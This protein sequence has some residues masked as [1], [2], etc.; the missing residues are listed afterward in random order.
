MKIQCL[1]AAGTVTGSR[2][3]LTTEKARVLI[4]CGLFQGYKT[5]REK[6]RAPLPFNAAELDAIVLT[7]A[8][9]DHS[10][11]LPVLCQK[12]FIGPVYCHPATQALCGILLP[13]SGHIQEEDARYANEH[14]TSKHQPALPL[15]DRKQAVAALKSLTPHDYFDPIEIGDLRLHL[16]PVGHILGAS[17]VVIEHKGK[18]VI[19]SGDVGRPDDILMNPPEPLPE[20]DA[21]FLES[22]YG[23]R[24]HESTSPWDTLADIVNQTA[25]LGGV[26]SIPCFAVG[27]AQTLQHMLDSLMAQRRIPDMPV[28]LDSPMAIDASHIYCR[29]RSFHRLDEA[30]CHAM[31]RRTRYLTSVEDSKSLNEITYPHI[32]LAG[33]GMITGGRI[34]HHLKRLIGNHRNSVVLA[35]YQAGGTRGARLAAGE[36]ALKIHNSY[37][38]VRARVYSL[39]GLSGHADYAEIIDWLKKTPILPGRVFLVH[40]EP[41]AADQM[42]IHLREQLDIDAHVAEM[43]ETISP[44]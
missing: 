29:F 6:N 13:D 40:G 5:L 8:H 23:N 44:F 12:G 24:R 30:Q 17:A 38:E 11:Y 9:L 3:L 7:H 15:Y 43:G 21:L 41:E 42:R 20:C 18:R 28:F 19:F 25:N 16:H 35:G 2:F 31:C 22:T 39:N 4:D 34:L 32:I 36:T 1:G 33:S 14:K 26:V 10:G 27:R 37:Y